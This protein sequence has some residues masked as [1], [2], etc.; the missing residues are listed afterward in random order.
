MITVRSGPTALVGSSLIVAWVGAFIFGYPGVL[1]RH[2]QET[3]GV[4]RGDVGASL[5][6]VLAAVGSCMFIAGRLQERFGIRAMMVAGV[7][8]CGLDVMA[9]PYAR[10]MRLVWVW[11]FVMG[12]ASCFMYLPALTTVQRWYPQKKGLMSGLVNFTFGFSAAVLS[13]L[14][15][16]MLRTVGY[17]SMNLILG[18]LV[19]VT[20]LAAAPFT[21]APRVSTPT[22]VFAFPV[23]T[24]SLSVS[25]AVRTANF[26]WLWVVWSIQGAAGISMVTLSTQF[27][28]SRGFDLDQ[29]VVILTAFGLTN[30]LGR[31]LMGWLSDRVGRRRAMSFTF[32]AA[33]IAYYLAPHTYGVADAAFLAAV[34]GFS[35][36]TLFAV[37][38]PLAI[39]CFGIQHFGSI[40]GLIFTGYGFL[41]GFLGPYVSGRILDATSG[42]FTL[43]F[44]YLGTYCFAGAALI[45]L[46]DPKRRPA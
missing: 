2:W 15:G 22:G 37:S 27:G 11:A 31:L 4:G 3:F 20:G 24:K 32:A 25:E 45:H 19:L 44:M 17:E 6:F 16:Y 33:G 7:V 5:F 30:G 8:A 43:V 14:F 34:I 21:G 41:A 12:A 26:R 35:F 13:P 18:G 1:G 36:G 42:N 46:V 40:Y 38:A 10:D 28:L 9:L 39:D 29:A 23:T